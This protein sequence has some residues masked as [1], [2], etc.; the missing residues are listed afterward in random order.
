MSILRAENEK[1]RALW[2]NASALVE[3]QSWYEASN[4]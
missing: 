1:L 2:F 3:M 4:L